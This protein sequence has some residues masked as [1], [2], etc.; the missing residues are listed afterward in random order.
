M[1]AKP[2]MT[3]SRRRKMVKNEARRNE[4]TALFVVIRM[5]MGEIPY[6]ATLLNTKKLR[7]YVSLMEQDHGLA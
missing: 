3:S 6:R 4:R 5:R 7:E 1:S 2:R